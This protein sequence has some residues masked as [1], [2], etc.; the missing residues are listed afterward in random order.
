MESALQR[1]F[2]GGELSP[3]LAARA[4]LAKYAAGLR[5]CRNFIVQ[6][7][8]G[9]ANRTGTRFIGECK[10]SSAIVQLVPY[11]HETP[12]ESILI[13]AGVNYLRFYQH[14]ALL[15]VETADLDDYA[16]GT[17]YVIGDTVKSGG[18]GYYCI[19]DHTG[20]AP[21]NATYWYA[22]PASGSNSIFELPTVFASAGNLFNYSQSG[23]TLTLTHRAHPPYEL[24][25]V[26]LTRWIIRAVTTAPQIDAPANLVL[27]GSA[28]A[29]KYGYVVTAAAPGSYEES[30]ASGQA[31]DLTAAAPTADAPHVLTWDALLVPPVTG[32]EA[33]EYYVYCDPYGNGTYGFIG[34]ATGDSS[35]RN[36][37]I[38]PDFTITPPLPRALFDDT[39]LY[40]HVSATFQQRRAFAQSVETP[41]GVWLSRVGFPSNF[42]IASPLQDDDAIT[43][44]IAGNDQHPVRH[45]VGLKVGLVMLTDGGEWTAVG[46]EGRSMI[47][48]G[49][50]VD[51]STYNGAAGDV[52]PAAVGNSIIYVQA[53]GSLVRELRFDIAVEGLGGKDLTV[54]AGHLFDGYTID[55]LS[56]AQTPHSI[57]WCVRSDG[58]LLGLTY[59]PEQDVWGWHRHDTDGRFEKVCVIPSPGEDQPYFIVSRTIGGSTKR[60]IERLEPRTI[61]N[62]NLDSFFVDAGLTYEGDAVDTVSG[63]DHLEGETVA[64]VA[65]GVALEG[66]F[67]VDGGAVSLPVS[68]SIIHVG[69]PIESAYI[70]TL[71][72][73]TSG[74]SIRDKKKRV[75][76]LT[77]LVENSSRT[78]SIGPD[79]LN[80]TE[81]VP[82]TYDPAGASF[83]GALELNIVSSFNENGRVVIQQT[84]P[85]PLTVLAVIPSVEVGG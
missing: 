61:M 82:A 14:G 74:T 40:P 64:V 36:P 22:F 50:A 5:T 49:I 32:D 39:G 58:T 84:D 37:G 34:T 53:R 63:L 69:L 26:S 68:A 33:P 24:I 16:G 65:D 13:E 52:R 62:W 28:G 38:D 20:H 15:E 80:L 18:V 35:F 10:T 30:E 66:P 27:T 6:R 46:Q 7:H 55:D 77:V 67:V 8:G 29:R 43:F 23:R 57:I 60:Y 47:P 70:E 4:D 1:S 56:Y 21:P 59:L 78:C 11:N 72:L 12:D 51:Q 2:A 73:D 48:N 85:L 42:G 25:Y 17:D 75:G 76:G 54:F 19:K 44:R 83:T 41:D 71:D 31:I 3:A 9:A 79:L 45:L 81:F